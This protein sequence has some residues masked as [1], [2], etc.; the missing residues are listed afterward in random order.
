MWATIAAA[1]IR[2]NSLCTGCIRMVNDNQSGQQQDGSRVWHVAGNCAGS[3]TTR[4]RS[5]SGHGVVVMD[6]AA[7]S[8]DHE[9]AAGSALLVSQRPAFEPFVE[10]RLSAR[11]IVKVVGGS[12]Q[13]ECAE[14]R[15]Y[16]LA[17]GAFTASSR[18]SPGLGPDGASSR[19]MNCWNL[20][21][22]RLK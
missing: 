17:R 16:S 8:H 1:I 7:P 19:S 20:S 11:K 5:S 6:T 14:R 13:R 15:T 22:S 2:P 10:Y 3:Q 18:S 21:A 12:Q 9:G 4:D